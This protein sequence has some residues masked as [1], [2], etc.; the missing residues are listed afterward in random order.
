MANI[1]QETALFGAIVLN[2]TCAFN[3]RK[4]SLNEDDY[5]LSRQE[6]I[7]A[8]SLI[9]QSN[10]QPGFKPRLTAFLILPAAN[11]G[12]DLPGASAHNIPQRHRQVH[13]GER[14]R[15]ALCD[16]KCQCQASDPSIPRP[17][18]HLVFSY[19]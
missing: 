6:R 1:F 10:V 12:L 14:G 8:R 3:P 13:G 17:P 2:S 4:I 15:G 16:P 19:G 9:S 18:K 5:S 7:C 11:S